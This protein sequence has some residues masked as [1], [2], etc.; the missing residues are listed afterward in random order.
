MGGE[1]GDG[2]GGSR[3]SLVTKVKAVVVVAEGAVR[4]DGEL[5]AA[6]VAPQVASEARAKM[7][8]VIL[9]VKAALDAKGKVGILA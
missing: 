8:P 3:G 4:F 6:E 2:G 5:K 9:A 1:R 7:Q